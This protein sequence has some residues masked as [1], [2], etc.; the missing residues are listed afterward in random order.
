KN[1][2][3]D[4]DTVITQF[5]KTSA[6]PYKFKRIDVSLDD[7]LFIS[8]LS[9]L[10]DL[11][12][13]VLTMVAENIISSIKRTYIESNSNVTKLEAPHDISPLP[14]KKTQISLLLNILN[15]DFDYSRIKDIDNIY[16]P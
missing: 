6:T 7:N 16:I 11:R 15:K 3:I 2:P 8:K 5:S 14:I 9:I 12:R 1:R 10:N 13:T 4:K